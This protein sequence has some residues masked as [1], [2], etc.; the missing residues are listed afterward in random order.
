MLHVRSLVSV[1]GGAKSFMK[2]GCNVILILTSKR[3]RAL[4]REKK[5]IKNVIY[6]FMFYTS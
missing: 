4:L 5:V 6:L 3:A 1:S 2:P